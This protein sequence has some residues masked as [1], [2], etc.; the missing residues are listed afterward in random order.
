[1]QLAGATG[2]TPLGTGPS[3]EIMGAAPTGKSLEME[4]RAL[5]Y[6]A[7][8]AFTKFQ[9]DSGTSYWALQRFNGW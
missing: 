3:G 7:F 8:R 6:A 2:A 9:G 1:M 5:A 4:A